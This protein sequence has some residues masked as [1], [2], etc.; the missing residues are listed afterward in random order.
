MLNGVFKALVFSSPEH[1]AG[2]LPAS[3]PAVERSTAYTGT[4]R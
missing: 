1:C 2:K 4:D 3:V